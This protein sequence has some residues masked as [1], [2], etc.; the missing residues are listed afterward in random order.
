MTRSGAN[1]IQQ[2][3]SMSEPQKKTKPMTVSEVTVQAYSSEHAKRIVAALYGV[4]YDAVLAAFPVHQGRANK[5]PTKC[6]TA[7]FPQQGTRQWETEYQIYTYA[8]RVPA[9]LNKWSY[10]GLEFVKGGF[11]HKT[12]AVKEMKTLSLKH[13]LP[14]MV[15][16]HKVLKKDSNVTAL[17]EPQ[18][19]MNSYRVEF[20]GQV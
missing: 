8:Q 20:I 3:A 2:V 13:R 11:K 9:G 17:A 15:Q 4:A 6:Q 18:M 1:A 7:D 5:T 10:I 14:M 16:I 19:Q 12:D